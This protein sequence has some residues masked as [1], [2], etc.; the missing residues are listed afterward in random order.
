MSSIVFTYDDDDKSYCDETDCGYL[1]IERKDGSR[2]CSNPDC[3]REYLPN[4]VNKHKRDL[5][6]IDHD[7]PIVV[8]MKDYGSYTKKKKQTVLDKE[9]KA[10]VAA[11]RGAGRSIIDIDEYWPEGEPK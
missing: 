9:E 5:Q 11:G 7:E 2:I 3:R 4:A 6:P 10:F 1:L 8:P